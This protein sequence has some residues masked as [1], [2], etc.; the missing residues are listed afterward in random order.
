[1]KK[2]I[3]FCFFSA[4]SLAATAQAVRMQN[5]AQLDADNGLLFS[6]N[7]GAY[8][9]QL[10]GFI[11]PSYRYLKAENADAQHFFNAKRSYFR[12]SGKAVEEKVSFLIQTNFSE[13]RPLLDA[14]VAYHPAEFLT[15]TFGQKQTFVNNREM[16]YREDRLQFTERGL[17]SEQLS[18]TGREFGLFLEGRFG[19]SFG[20]EPMLAITSGDGRNSFGVD[21]RDTDLGGLKYGGRLDLYPLGFFSQ[22]NELYS[23]D[24]LHEK[25]PKLVFGTAM[26]TNQ[27]ASHALGEGHGDFLLYNKNGKVSLPNYR[28][29][30]IDLLAKYKGFSL[31]AEFGNASASGLSENYSDANAVLLLA[32]QQIGSYLQL[33]NSYNA[34]L[35]YVTKK[36]YSVDL[37]YGQSLPEFANYTNSLM[38]GTSSYTLGLT[39]YIKGHNLKAQT[40]FTWLSS[41]AGVNTNILE[42]MMQIA[43]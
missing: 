13:Q 28:Q 40:A 22:G 3:L 34:Q 24:L 16:L 27:G 8:Q 35:G 37:R 39:R 10:G 38:Q 6:L 31:L 21:S 15:V 29:L 5:S 9:F 1:M 18:R 23:A 30:Y 26:S 11:Q 25:S 4:C 14:W 43:F 12:I 19:E 20:I 33:G 2:Y 17:L 42:V 41:E 36:G 7:D 32:P